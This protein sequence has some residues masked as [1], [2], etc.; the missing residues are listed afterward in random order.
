MMGNERTR[1]I[2]AALKRCM[3]AAEMMLKKS[4]K[5]VIAFY[6]FS[7]FNMLPIV[8]GKLLISDELF[9]SLVSVQ[10]KKCKTDIRVHY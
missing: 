3:I 9:F 2:T 6:V 8:Y 5:E 4:K 7:F 10:V 1:T